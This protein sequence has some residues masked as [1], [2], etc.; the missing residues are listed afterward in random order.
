MCSRCFESKLLMKH[1]SWAFHHR[2]PF[3]IRASS[4]LAELEIFRKHFDWNPLGF[5][6]RTFPVVAQRSLRLNNLKC[7]L[8]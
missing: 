1:L 4:R 5:F 7:F 2:I 3:Y 6:R 8:F